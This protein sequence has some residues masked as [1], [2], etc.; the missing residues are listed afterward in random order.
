MKI[1]N[2]KNLKVKFSKNFLTLTLS[3]FGIKSLLIVSF[4]LSIDA[5]KKPF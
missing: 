4:I 1:P 5:D 3:A 2:G